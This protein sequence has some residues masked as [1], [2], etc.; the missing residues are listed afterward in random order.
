MTGIFKTVILIRGRPQPEWAR[1]PDPFW[2]RAV[3]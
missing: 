1:S 2:P 3:F